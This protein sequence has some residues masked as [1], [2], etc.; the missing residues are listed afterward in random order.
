MC[1][2]RERQTEKDRQAETER[3]RGREI[4]ISAGYCRYTKCTT[5]KNN[6]KVNYS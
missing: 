2:V 1:C 6:S 5:T 3:D 4:K